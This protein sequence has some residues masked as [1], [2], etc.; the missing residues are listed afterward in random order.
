MA[1]AWR[2]CRW[3]KRLSINYQLLSIVRL[4]CGLLF[5]CHLFACLWGLQAS[6]DQLGSWPGASGYC[7]AWEVGDPC[8]S[9]K[10]CNEYAETACESSSAM[11]LYS[12]YFALATVTSIGYGDV[13]ATAFNAVEQVAT[14]A[15]PAGR[16]ATAAACRVAERRPGSESEV[17]A[18]ARSRSGV[19]PDRPPGYSPKQAAGASSPAK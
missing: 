7:A 15:P 19:L 3:E 11:W 13:N 16:A 2:A 10:V 18:L 5:G 12:F 8:P 4:L 6:F 1:C 14:A 17:A 9:G